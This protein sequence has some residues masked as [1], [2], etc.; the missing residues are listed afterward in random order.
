MAF[1]IYAN[2]TRPRNLKIVT[3][4]Q[5]KT[6]INTRTLKALVVLTVMKY[7]T[8]KQ[9]DVQIKEYYFFWTE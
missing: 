5:A 1:E 3:V 4:S 8:I 6:S 9:Q 7:Y 2:I